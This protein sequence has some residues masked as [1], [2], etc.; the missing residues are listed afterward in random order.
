MLAP[1]RLAVVCLFLITGLVLVRS[2]VPHSSARR[3]LDKEPRTVP[4]RAQSQHVAKLP[5]WPFGTPVL[6]DH[7]VED[8]DMADA[9]EEETVL[10]DGD[11]F[12]EDGGSQS[13]FYQVPISTPND[14]TI[15][16]GKSKQQNTDWVLNE[17]NEWRSV[18][19]TIDDQTAPLHTV[20]NKGLESLAYLQFIIEH[21]H[22]LPNLIIFLQA[23]REGYPQVRNRLR[24]SHDGHLGRH[25]P[26]SAYDNVRAVKA[27]RED[28]VQQEGY[29]N[30]RCSLNPG[31]PDGLQ[32][33]RDPQDPSGGGETERVFAMAW[34]QLF[35]NTDIPE[36]VAVPCCS[37][38]AVSRNQVLKRPL[39]DYITYLRWLIK[40]EL[41]DE[42][43]TTIMENLWHVIFG[44]GSVHC[45]SM[46]QC[47]RD[48]FG[49]GL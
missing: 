16:V 15:V 26:R 27:L 29:V 40:T 39:D 33:F 4:F 37:Q 17:L 10:G 7:E 35:N 21:Y 44:K 13:V 32:P 19:Y 8:G 45:P 11:R 43:S 34:E 31:C 48:V 5:Y 1:A 28:Y 14:R 6:Y 36:V 18:I 3:R 20:I 46:R 24:E 9:D 49:V 2:R 41:P 22:N 38:F 23:S 42:V 47:Y 25:I 30:L 12:L